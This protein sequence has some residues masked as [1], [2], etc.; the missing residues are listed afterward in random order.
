M[1]LL[2]EGHYDVDFEDIVGATRSEVIDDG[3]AVVSRNQL[4]NKQAAVLAGQR[5]MAAS[6]AQP[7][8]RIHRPTR[9][10]RK[11]ATSMFDNLNLYFKHGGQTGCV[12]TWA[13][14]PPPRPVSCQLCPSCLVAV[15]EASES[16]GNAR[17]EEEAALSEVEDCRGKASQQESDAEEESSEENSEMDG[18]L[19][20][21][22]AARSS[23]L[24]ILA[25]DNCG[26]PAKARKTAAGPRSQRSCEPDLC[27]LQHGLDYSEFKRRGCD[28]SRCG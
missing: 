18:E 16:S 23:I 6:S 7:R 25:D 10:A 26:Q 11:S 13:R 21:L 27:D 8:L 4:A 17:L 5:K 3:E 20:R 22:A 15:S 12:A 24:G 2:P 28:S 14:F 1:P 19:S 9:H